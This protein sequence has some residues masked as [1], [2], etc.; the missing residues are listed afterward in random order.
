MAD[1]LDEDTRVHLRIDCGIDGCENILVFV[2]QK[3]DLFSTTINK[4]FG[5]MKSVGWAM[6]EDYNFIC[7]DHAHPQQENK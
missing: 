2:F 3:D 1:N 6:N 7:T 4:F 5:F